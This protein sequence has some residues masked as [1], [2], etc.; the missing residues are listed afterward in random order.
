[1]SDLVMNTRTHELESRVAA[2]EELL[3]SLERTIVEQ[4]EHLER[5]GEAE[6]HLAAIVQSADAA[7][8]SLALDF[9]ILTWNAAA[10]RLFGYTPEEVIGRRADEV[11]TPAADRERALIQFSE[12]IKNFTGPRSTPR[13]FEETAQ[14]GDGTTVDVAL[15]VSGIYDADSQLTG[16][17]VIVRDISDRKHAEGEQAALATI[18]NASQDAIIGYSKDLKITIWNPAAERIYGFSA[19]EA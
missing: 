3:G 9:R 14:R 1:M 13:Y 5:G 16:A 10:E 7:I 4:S 11:F 15:V 17:S 12:D 2:L 8:I 19:K 6:S 18:V